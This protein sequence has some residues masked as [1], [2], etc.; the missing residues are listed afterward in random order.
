MTRI[1]YISIGVLILL[2][3]C[4]EGEKKYLFKFIDSSHSDIHFSNTIQENDS[5][6]IIDF[7]YCYNGGGV[8]I[9]DFNMDGLPDIIFT[10]N[11]VSSKIYLNLGNLKFKDVSEIANFTT[12]SWVT[13]V[14]IVDLNSDGFDDIYLSVGG[15]NCKDDCNNLLFINQGTNSQGIPKFIEQAEEYGLDDGRYAQQS[16]FF[17]Y[18][19]DGDLDVYIAHNGNTSYD[20]NTPMP[21]RYVPEHLSDYMLKNE[22]LPDVDHPVF[23]NV[24]DEVGINKKG[25]SLGVTINDFND[26]NLPDVYVTNDF[27]TEDLL[28]LNQ[29]I[30]GSS[31]S[32]FQEA[33]QH[34]LS[35]ET[36][37]SMGVDI[38]DINNDLLPDIMALD[39]LPNE[40]QRQKKMLGAMNYDKYLL[41]LSNGYSSQYMHNTLQINNGK[42]NDKLLKASEIAF[43]S[44]ISS[45]DWSW[46]P[47]IIDLDNDG[48][49]DIHITNGYTKDITDLDF[50]NYNNL[51]NVFGT[52]ETRD[53]ELKK[54]VK[55]LPEVALNNFI[56]ENKGSLKFSNVSEV[57]SAEK[58]SLSNGAAYADLDL[59]GDLDLIINN[60]NAKAF[61]I[62]NKASE[63][64]KNK[65]LRI[66]LKGT[67]QNPK[68]IG[69][70]ITLWSNGEAQSNYQS[71][72]RGYLSSVEPIVHFGTKSSVIDSLRVIWPN[73]GLTL[74]TEIKANQVIELNQEDQKLDA[75]PNP[76]KSYLF[77]ETKGVL[78]FKHIENQ[79]NDYV[80]QRL[81]MKQYSKTGPS[82]AVGNLDGNIGDEI[83]IGGS[84]NQPGQIL[85]QDVSGKYVQK[86][87]LDADYEDTDAVFIDIDGDN[88]L[89]LYVASGSNEF[90]RD[91]NLY[92]DRIYLNNGSGS[93]EK[94]S[95]ALPEFNEST[96]CVRP[97]DF[98][99]DG[100]ID[101]FIGAGIVPRAYPSIPQSR[102]L[103]NHEGNFTEAV[104]PEL[105]NIGM[106]NDAIWEDID[107]DSWPD[108]IVVGKW[109]P[110]SIF[111]NNQGKLTPMPI[112]WIIGN[113][114][115][116]STSGW[117]NCI[118][119]GDFDN[120]GDVDFL[121]GNQGTNGFVQP[122]AEYPVYIYTGDFDNNGSIDPIL[123]KYFQINTDKK[124]MPVQTRD[125]IIQQL[126]ALKND[127]LTYDEFSQIDFL[128]LLDINDTSKKTLKASIFESCYIENLGNGTFKVRPLPES[129]QLAPINDL[130]IQDFDKDGNLDALLV[131]NDFT[132]ESLY[133]RF[134]AH[135]GIF[136]K[137]NGS[138]EF[139]A[140]PSKTSGFYVPNQSNSIVQLK[141]NTEEKLILAG[142]NNDSIKVFKIRAKNTTTIIAAE[143]IDK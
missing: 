7:Q 3:G 23:V 28:Y 124:L 61:L 119:S 46:S 16:V 98:D 127:H 111:K 10:G 4:S 37:N 8:G 117:W 74:L 47:L 1:L 88:D 25:F 134:D 129:C 84:K 29:K 142:Q 2:S 79:S 86:Q 70:K 121:L 83:F 5:I 133:G 20:K 52:P 33:S 21:K 59:D 24:S 143:A 80:F 125:D 41:S 14:S 122:S 72:V 35:H 92:Q 39:M 58:K 113:E 22:S 128:N 67:A 54:M 139:Q 93:F 64:Q 137:G 26:D 44:G 56:Y 50:I 32:K 9:G 110:I 31:S 97:A 126:V 130:E 19:Q 87:E 89:D 42:I 103:I 55:G 6:N 85:F 99:N 81:L 104:I 57:W 13:G 90:S 12:S 96:S 118:K 73:G 51:N 102:I 62:E 94:N 91:S 69:A 101:F 49:K 115:S 132:A 76:S 140:I 120:D 66:K 38:A 53:R 106:V 17:D 78:N 63:N 138:G 11:Q 136:L 34:Y 141:D 48:D 68:A 30:E 123:A 109:M 116:A 114:A 100:D 112:D 15:A 77:T 65:Y 27:I 131:G 95:M 71:V 108:L 82:I 105:Q 18:D 40:Y 75:K 36:Y 60:I 107:G 135:I 45:T 43:F